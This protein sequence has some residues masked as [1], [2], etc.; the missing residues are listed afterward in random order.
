MTEPIIC[1]GY[2][3]EMNATPE[4]QEMVDK[5]SLYT[6]WKEWTVK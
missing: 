4:I 3:E 5:V 1:G 2:G 6:Y